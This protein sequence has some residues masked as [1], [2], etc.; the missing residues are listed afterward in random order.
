MQ[1]LNKKMDKQNGD[2][3]VEQNHHDYQNSVGA[4]LSE[5]EKKRKV[6]ICLSSVHFTKKLIALICMLWRFRT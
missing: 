1:S 5:T 6:S 2:S 3:N 4:L